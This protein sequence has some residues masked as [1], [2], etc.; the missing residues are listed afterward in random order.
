MKEKTRVIELKNSC[1]NEAM[2]SETTVCASIDLQQAIYLP[3]SNES[4]IFYRRRL[5]I[6][7][8]T[9]YDIGTKD[10]HCFTW[11]ETQ[12]KRGSSEI[13]TSVYRA[14]KL[15]DDKGI[16]KAYH[17]S[18]GCSGQNKNSI[19]P[20]MMLYT[21][22]HSVNLEEIS[23]RFFETNH[24]QNE[25]DSAHSA[26]GHALKNAG[27]VFLP[28]QVTTVMSL[29]RPS[30][31]YIVTQMQGEDFVDF[32]TLS[33]DLRIIDAGRDEGFTWN[34]IMELKVLKSEPNKMFYKTSH[35]QNTYNVYSLKRITTSIENCTLKKLNEGAINISKQKYDDLV[36]LCSGPIP[37]VKLENHKMFYHSLPHDKN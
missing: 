25:G 35:L 12:S 1:K 4:K 30:K 20:A 29:A 23:L 36:S 27:N 28:S 2:E 16:K 14:L 7:N 11:D 26:I 21:V 34:S 5:S 17:S 3:I 9:V 6:Y 22:T 33:K 15:Y 13:S 18:D 32:K 19:T 37:V 8:L 24:G 31:P 10:C